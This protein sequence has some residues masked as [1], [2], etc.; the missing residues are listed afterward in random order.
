[1]PVVRS[2]R[3]RTTIGALCLALALGAGGCDAEYERTENLSYDPAIAYQGTFDAYEPVADSGRV[4]R[5]AIVAIHGGARRGGD[6]AWG[7]QFAKELCPR[8]SIAR[9]AAM[10]ARLETRGRTGRRT[11]SAHPLRCVLSSAA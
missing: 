2:L 8:G 4:K 10:I 11:H 7:E 5:P 9:S 1:M 3:R 6:K